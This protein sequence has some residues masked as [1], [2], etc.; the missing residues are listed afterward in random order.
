L[1]RFFFVGAAGKEKKLYL[2]WKFEEI[3]ILIDSSE[4]V[5]QR[6]SHK[7]FKEESSSDEDPQKRRSIV[8]LWSDLEIRS[9]VHQST[10][11]M[12]MMTIWWCRW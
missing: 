11:I 1:L 4:F 7:K 3:D 2:L 10:S 8:Q 5:Q 6:I 12:T 9:F